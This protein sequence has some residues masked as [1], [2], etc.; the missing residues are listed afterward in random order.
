MFRIG[1]FSQLTG[2]TIKALRYYDRVGLLKPAEVDRFTGYRYYTVVQ[3]DRLNRILALK[4]LGLSLDEVRQ[5]LCENPTAEELRGM[6]RLKQAQLR[7]TITEEQARLERVEARLRQIEREG[8]LPAH[9]VIVREVAPQ[10]VLRYREILPGPWEIKPFFIRIGTAIQS[11][12]VEATGPWLAL[13]WHGEYR[14]HDLDVEAAIPVGD[15]APTSLPLDAERSME[16][17]TLPAVTVAA[18]ICRMASQADVYAANRDLCA[19]IAANGYTIL[20]APC[21]EVYAAAPQPGEPVIFE[22]QLPVT[23]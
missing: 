17:G 7:Q 4:D 12:M 3:I 19:W 14:E 11:A 10:K 1:L 21:R 6:L 23:R 2:V 15:G 20:N 5:V 16:S 8:E 9:E 22:V 13:Y 18:T